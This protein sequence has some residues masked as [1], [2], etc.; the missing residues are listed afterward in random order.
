M[1]TSKDLAT[2]R[3]V[4]DN[5]ASSVEPF[6]T[7][8]AGREIEFDGN[9]AAQAPHADPNDLRHDI[10]IGPGDKGAISAFGPSFQYQNVSDRDLHLTG[11]D[12]LKVGDKLHDVAEVGYYN[13]DSCH[14]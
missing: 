13:T 11:S 12:S 14:S 5:R 7:E 10:L 9:V 1:K 6:A 4:G 3:K 2:L 8:Y